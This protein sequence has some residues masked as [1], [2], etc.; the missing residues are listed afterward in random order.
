[1]SELTGRPPG[2][3]RYLG[4][5]VNRKPR[6]ILE[7]IYWLLCPSK[8]KTDRIYVPIYPGHP[9]YP[10]ACYSAEQVISE[11]PFALYPLD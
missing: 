2:G 7:R 9:D 5:R 8:I 3:V 4:K 6:H 11:R 1:M 10:N